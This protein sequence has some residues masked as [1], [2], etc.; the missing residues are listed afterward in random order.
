MKSL[1]ARYHSHMF[2]PPNA[3]FSAEN[4][5]DELSEGAKENPEINKEI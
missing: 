5:G 2:P 3:N 4:L 1:E